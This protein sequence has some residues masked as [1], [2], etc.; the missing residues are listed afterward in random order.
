MRDVLSGEIPFIL[1][2]DLYAT[3]AIAGAASYFGFKLVGVQHS[4][5]FYSGMVVVFAIRIL[6]IVWR[7][8]FP[9]LQLPQHHK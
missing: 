8:S 9:I 5:A 3:A 1:K 6:S 7:V 4:F 2:K